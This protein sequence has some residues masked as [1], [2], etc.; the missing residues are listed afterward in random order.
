[1]CQDRAIHQVIHHLL[2]EVIRFNNFLYRIRPSWVEGLGLG[3]WCL[4]PLSTIFQFHWWRKPQYPEKTTDL[5][6][7]N[8]KLYHIMLFRVDLAMNGVPT[9]NFSGDRH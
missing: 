1:M 5:S 9:H 6:E 4:M 2:L 8:D 3:V 7:V